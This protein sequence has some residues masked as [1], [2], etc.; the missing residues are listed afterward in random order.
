MKYR[1][2]VAVLGGSI[3]IINSKDEVISLRKYPESLD[4]IKKGMWRNTIS[5]SSVMFRKS[6]ILKEGSY[7]TKL[8]RGQDYELWFRLLKKGYVLNNLSDVISCWRFEP[9][10]FFKSSFKQ[11]LQQA[12]VGFNG[13]RSIKLPLWKQ[14]LCFVPLTLYLFPR[15]FSKYYTKLKNLIHK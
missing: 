4:S 15:G 5:H 12:I 3:K 14:L 7:S 6:I 9:N 10:D 13:S 2:D 11:K 8:R 1:S